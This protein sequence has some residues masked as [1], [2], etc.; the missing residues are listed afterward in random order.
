MTSTAE[1]VSEHVNSLIESLEDKLANPTTL[2]PPG[3]GPSCAA[4]RKGGA[5]PEARGVAGVVLGLLFDKEAISAGLLKL[6]DAMRAVAQSFTDAAAAVAES[7]REIAARIAEFPATL[8]NVAA[9]LAGL[10]GL[11]LGLANDDALTPKDLATM[12][13]GT[14]D[15]LGVASAEL[16][17][18]DLPTLDSA[19]LMLSLQVLDLAV[20]LAPVCSSLCMSCSAL[21]VCAG[22]RHVRR[23]SA[24]DNQG[25]HRAQEI[26]RRRYQAR[27]GGAVERRRRAR[28]SDR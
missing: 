6:V 14:A 23:R 11:W 2:L 17:G 26:V 5:G 1:T 18:F 20:A 19:P 16:A 8:T 10:G 9:Q 25:A 3:N 22:V 13:N 27:R 21:P 4:S 28:C 12:L 7:I 24:D 15:K